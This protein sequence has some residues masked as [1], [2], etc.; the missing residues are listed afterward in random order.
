MP[1]DSQVIRLSEHT[2]A[3]GTMCDIS[4]NRLV[5]Q[6]SSLGSRRDFLG[7]A[8]ALALTRIAAS[9]RGPAEAEGF[10][11]SGPQRITLAQVM[12]TRDVKQNLAKARAVFD[13]AR[14]DGADWVLF[15]EGF[16]SGYYTGFSQSEVAAAFGEVQGLCRECRVVG[17]IGTGWKEHGK[18]YD[19]IRI[20]DA[21]ANLAGQYAKTCLCYYDRDCGFTSDGFPMIHVLGGIKFGTLICNDLWV[22]PGFSD[23]PDPHLTLRLA[24][25]GAQVIFDAVN[26]GNNLNLR[27]YQEANLT[28]R[29][30]EAKCPIV[31]VN[32]FT[33]PASNVTSGVVGTDF[34]YLEVLPRDR[35]VIKTV[36]FIPAR[37]QH[38]P[39]AATVP[40]ERQ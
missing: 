11:G 23:G 18:I 36:S 40:E 3:A 5:H 31:A 7:S 37:R 13:Q 14:K 28:I 22:T 24:R 17:L 12:A 25:E 8:A 35:E 10:S 27:A 16:L 21:A 29:A 9:S 34:K 38:G 2:K 26:S 19:Q 4:E 20:V 33:P 1:H 30:W 32:A 6:G 39:L 15:P